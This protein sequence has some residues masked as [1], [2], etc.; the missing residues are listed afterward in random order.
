MASEL[1]FNNE[2][3]SLTP[4]ND[5]EEDGEENV[6]L[7]KYADQPSIMPSD[8]TK[9]RQNSSVVSISSQNAKSKITQL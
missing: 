3:A 2:N 6:D 4:T 8:M 5:E 9:L 1:D 7:V